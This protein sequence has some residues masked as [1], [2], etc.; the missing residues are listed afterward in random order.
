MSRFPPES[1]SIVANIFANLGDL[2]HATYRKANGLAKY[3][4]IGPSIPSIMRSWAT[5]PY[6][7]CVLARSE[8]A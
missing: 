6:G 3:I 2:S 4:G 5:F 7:V 8:M 1:R